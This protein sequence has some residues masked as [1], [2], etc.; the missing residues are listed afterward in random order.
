[1]I[2]LLIAKYV[3]AIDRTSIASCQYVRQLHLVSTSQFTRGVIQIWRLS[4]P[5]AFTNRPGQRIDSDS[6]L[7][8]FLSFLS[9]LLSFFFFFLCRVR[10][11]SP[12][13]SAP[14]K[15][16]TSIFSIEILSIKQSLISLFRQSFC[17]LAASLYE[18]LDCSSS[19]SVS[20]SFLS[21]STSF[22]LVYFALFASFSLLFAR[23]FFDA[24]RSFIFTPY[25][26]ELTGLTHT[27][28]S[29]AS[30]SL[31]AYVFCWT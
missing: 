7:S 17:K 15:P 22:L 21:S 30:L 12:Y 13:C 23:S 14:S 3:L 11:S 31:A 26:P 27:S 28:P 25:V 9:S 2:V 19:S 6:D 16:E 20:L 1:M 5:T 8:P 18:C 10:T 24:S 4:P 29:S